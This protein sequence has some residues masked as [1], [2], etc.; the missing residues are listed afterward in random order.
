MQ[1]LARVGITAEAVIWDDL[2]SLWSSY[3]LVL[4]RSTWDYVLRRDAFLDWA[5]A[6]PRVANPASVLTWNTDKRYLGELAEAGL[7]AVLT[8]FAGPDAEPELPP[9]PEYV[10][11]PTISAGSADTARWRLGFDDEAALAHLGALR[12]AG[13]TAML[14]PYLAGV[15]EAGESALIYLGGVFS[16]S[17]RKGPILTVGTPPSSIAIGDH[18]EREQITARTA[19]PDE[20]ALAERVLDAV[21]GGREQLVYAR[22]DLL[23]GPG[24]TPVLLELELTEPSLFLFAD[25]AA[26]DR[27]AAAVSAALAT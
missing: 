18:D 5:G 9:W 7:P 15:D 6:L 10:I 24:G 20:L 23:P 4:I 19:T 22:V 17:V 11:K 3:D 26:A 16:H 27:L 8:R 2:A 13:R 1:A 21:P 14:Q 12:E 25:P